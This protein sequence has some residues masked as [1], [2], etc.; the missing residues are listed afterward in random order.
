[1]SIRRAKA[2]EGLRAV[3]NWPRPSI[4]KACLDFNSNLLHME[5]VAGVEFYLGSNLRLTRRVMKTVRVHQWRSDVLTYED[6]PVPEIK[7]GEARVKIEASGV[8]YRHYQRTRLSAEH[9]FHQGTEGRGSSTRSDQ[10]Q[11]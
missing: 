6:I 9:T 7:A 10:S 4:A 1:M 8:N 11:K 2:V 5:W 3:E